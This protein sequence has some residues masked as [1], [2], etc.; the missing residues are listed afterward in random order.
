[1][2]RLSGVLLAGFM[3]HLNVERADLAC[4][5]HTDHVTRVTPAPAAHVHDGHH[6]AMAGAEHGAATESES[7]QTPTQPDCCQALASCSLVLGMDDA[8][9]L[10]RS[11]QSHILVLAGVQSAPLSR[12]AAPDPPPPKL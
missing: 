3:L 10:V 12:L 7:C 11:S 8:P 6:H 1:M 9:M 5:A 4:A 2:R